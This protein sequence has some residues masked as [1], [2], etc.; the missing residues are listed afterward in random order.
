VIISQIIGGLGNQMFQYAAGW[1]LAKSKGTSLKL[2][3]S[4]F[5]GYRLHQGFELERVFEAEINIATQGDAKQVLG[6]QAVGYANNIL[7]RPW[8]AAFRKP[9]M[10]VEPHFR[11]CDLASIIDKAG[12]LYGYWQSEKY[13]LDYAD[14]IRRQFQFKQ[15]LNAENKKWMALIVNRN[16]VGIHVRRGDFISKVNTGVHGACTVDYFSSAIAHMAARVPNPEFFF[17]SDDMDWVRGNIAMDFP[18]Y[19]IENNVGADS[20]NDMRLMS[21]CKH[22]IVANS[23]FSWW[24]GWLNRNDS[25]I[26]IAPKRWFANDFDTRD[27][28]PKDWVV[29]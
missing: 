28:L 8:M 11:Y 26:V 27:L 18:C 22:N 2:D 16:S 15:P 23:S 3:I 25:K 29:L 17:F 7:R 5:S 10:L 19:F 6:W 24:G 9:S 1:A 21:L 4:S 20:F 12:Y 13:F 14:E